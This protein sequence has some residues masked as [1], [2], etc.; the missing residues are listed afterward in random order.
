MTI[1]RLTGQMLQSTLLRDGV[2]LS[3]Q[4]T[5]NSV[6][7]LYLDIG[8]TRV[9]ILTQLP[10]AELDVNGNILANNLTANAGFYGNSGYFT[11]NVQV[12]GNLITTGNAIIYANSGIFY[13]DTVTGN[14]AVFA[15]VPA[16]TQIGTNVVAQFSGN[17]NS[18]SQINFENINDGTEASTD[19]IVTANNGND[20]ANF[21][22]FGIGSNTYAPVAYPAYGINDAYLLNN[23]GNLLLNAQSPG[24][25]IKFIVGGSANSDVIAT[26]SNTELSVTGNIGA[27]INVSANGNVTAGNVSAIGNVDAAVVNANIFGNLTGNVD[28]YDVV[29]SN[30]VTSP[31]FTSTGVLNIVSQSAGNILIDAAGYTR[32]VGTDAFYVP[33]G[34]TFDRPSSPEVGAV[35]FNTTTTSLEVWDGTIWAAATND[36]SVISN[37]TINP[38]GSTTTFTLDQSTTAESILVTVNG[39]NQTPTTDYIVVGDQLTFTTTPI[40]T[41]TVQIRFIAST[42]TVTGI[43]N[44]NSYVTIDSANSNVTVSV[45]GTNNVGVFATAGLYVSGL[46]ASANVALPVYSVA[47]ATALSG[48]AT[49]QVIYVS[50]G[51]NGNPCLAVYSGGTWKR[52]ALG[53]TISS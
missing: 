32:I 48:I 5:A 7:T 30:A 1:S 20:I 23:G 36:L 34:N 26:I 16:F 9:G 50:N 47:T 52:V 45:N 3:V 10:A 11:G 49:G 17:V 42:S 38:D 21:A 28:V 18:Y 31:T 19:F 6:P 37:Q 4:D 51:D 40:V 44:A 41:D 33:V 24:K 27:S 13:G 8:N 12:L 15:G 25:I 43:V 14:N 53:T 46:F 29:A 2:N 39:L 35:R 22:N